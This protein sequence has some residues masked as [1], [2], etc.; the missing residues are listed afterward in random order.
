MGRMAASLLTRLVDGQRLE[1]LGVE[2]GTKLIVRE[3]TAPPRA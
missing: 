1:A 3:S 2:L